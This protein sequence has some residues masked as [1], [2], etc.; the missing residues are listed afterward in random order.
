MRTIQQ[1]IH[2]AADGHGAVYDSPYSGR[3]MYG[4]NCIAIAGSWST[5]QKVIAD[6]IKTMAAEAFDDYEADDR[7]TGTLGSEF[8]TAVDSI[9]DFSFDQL[10]VDMIIYWPDI[11]FEEKK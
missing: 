7:D 4:R 9:L 2:D 3:A 5:C 10:G 8:D 11:D 1:F 6:A